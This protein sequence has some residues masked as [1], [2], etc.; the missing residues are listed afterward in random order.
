M[1]RHNQAAPVCEETPGVSI[2]VVS[3]SG[4]ILSASG[5]AIAAMGPESTDLSGRVLG[6]ILCPDDVAGVETAI[7]ALDGGQV[8]ATDVELG[9]LCAGGVC[10]RFRAFLSPVRADDRMVAV[11]MVLH[12][13]GKERAGPTVSSAPDP[14]RQFDPGLMRQAARHFGFA[15]WFLEPATRAMWATEAYFDLLGFEPDEVELSGPW[16][17]SRLHPDDFDATVSRMEQLL[18]NENETFAIDY[19]LRCKDGT[20]KWFQ[21]NARLYSRKGTGLPPVVCGSLIDIS[22]RKANESRLNAARAKA[23]AARAEAEKSESLLHIATEH[24]GVAP[25]F[26]N[27]AT[28]EFVRNDRFGTIT[29][30]TGDGL[31]KTLDGMLGMVHPDDLPMVQRELAA[32]VQGK[33]AEAKADHRIRHKDGHWV[34]CTSVAKPYQSGEDGQPL[35][36]CGTTFDI[37]DH[38]AYEAR[39]AEALRAAQ[40]AREE[41]QEAAEILRHSTENSNVVPWYRYPD[42]GQD[43]VGD[44]LKTMLGH[45]PE[46]EIDRP[47]FLDLMHPDDRSAAKADFWAMDRGEIDAYDHSFRLRR[48]D[49]TWCWF[50]AMAKRVDRSDQ[51]RP[52]LICGSLTDIDDLKRNEARL[53]EAASEAQQAQD[54]L[55]KLADNMP[56]A[57]AER[58]GWPDG[59]SSLPY[60]SARLPE[61]F[62]TTRDAIE[63]D[64]TALYVHMH[65]DDRARLVER[66]DQ[67]AAEL[68][69]FDERVRIMDPETGPRWVRI[70][71]QPF[72]Q[73][74]G[75]VIW[76]GNVNDI[77]AQVETEQRAEEAAAR[78]RFLE[79]RLR[80]A[81]E[82]AGIGVW[83]FDLVSGQLVWDDTMHR[84]HGI[85]PGSFGGRLEGWVDLVHPEDIAASERRFSAAVQSGSAF[86]DAFRIVRP[87]GTVRVISARAQIFRDASGAPV[88]A[89]GVNMDVTEQKAAELHLAEAAEDARR[90]HDR[91]NILA[92]NAPGALFE[93][94]QDS[95]GVFSLP[96]FSANLAPIM[97]VTAEALAA[98]GAA[99]F[100]HI[101]PEDLPKVVEDIAISRADLSDFT[102]RFRINDPR[103]GLRWVMVS[104]LPSL[105]SDGAVVWYGNMFDVTEQEK[106]ER[107]AAAA[108]KELRVANDRFLSMAENAPGAIFECHMAPDGE[109]DFKFLSSTLLDLMGV[110]RGD[111]VAKGR[112][113]F[114]RIPQE[115]AELI[116]PQIMQCAADLRPYEVKHRVDHPEKGLR[117]VMAAANPSLQP[118]GSI[119]W[120][121]SVV[122]ITDRLEMEHR[123]AQAAE[124][125][126][127]AH[128]SL[129]L[130]ADIST[131]GLYEFCLQPDGTTKL[132][133]FSARFAELVGFAR[134]D[135]EKSDEGVFARIPEEDLPAV[136]AAI[137]KSHRDLVP[138][139]VRFRL[140][141]PDRG[142]VW[143][144]AAANAPRLK[145]GVFTWS[146]ALS[147]VT[148]VV[149]REQELR[150]AHRLAEDMRAENERQALH[151]GLTG[152]PNRR[153]Y[154]KMIAERLASAVDGGPRDCA[155]IRLD[156]DHFKY[157][158]D[159]LGHEAG[160][161]VL[162]R[163]AAVLRDCLREGDFVA[164]I[165]GD[166][167]SI[168][169]APG[170]SEV[171][172]EALVEEI[173]VRLAEPLIYEGRQCRYG[174][175]FGIAQTEDV[176]EMGEDIQMFADAALY[177]AK[178]SGRNRLEVFTPD[179][180]REILTDRRL[181]VEIHE[182]LDR[183]QF[184]PFF[185][186]QVAAD[187]GRLVG[188][189]TLLRWK[190]PVEGL[191]S[192]DAFMHVAEQLRLVPEIDRIMMEKSRD[193][194]ANWREQGLIVPKISFNVSSGRMHDPS[195]VALAGEMASGETRVTFE[196][197]ESILVE[198]ENDT[199][200]C[201]LDMLR[202]VGVDIE[203][204]DFGS[205]HASIIGVMEIAPSALKI[206]K[207]I[208]LPV[209]QDLRARSLVRAIV[210]IADTLGIN[211]VAEGVETE[212][213]ARILRGI[214]CDVLQGYLFARPLSEDQLLTY[215]LGD[216]LSKALAGGR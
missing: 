6:D 32:M 128:D 166:E 192:P 172:A 190:H 33:Q 46:F 105:Q 124:E 208:V 116:L 86:D 100:A 213:Q 178:A 138:F 50:S 83:D 5:A 137:A 77:T 66:V 13:P 87:D 171:E 157:V 167:F 183:D 127:R 176:S 41:A 1:Q 122:D 107:Q 195:V 109:M 42:F 23:D 197:L 133:Y 64:S 141:H 130:L 82:A 95:A 2:L 106:V 57:L 98:D 18:A 75:S 35:L 200:R 80:L 187:D 115:D 103:T 59:T 182:G 69:A 132:S 22:R 96:Y 140:R 43:R 205:G 62:A 48:A 143:V 84:I 177:R 112:N 161:L 74:D 148:P 152:L 125:L 108:A 51:G 49:G 30:R 159:T 90:A 39:L 131:V 207:R 210:E 20:Y 21:A 204:D 194:L 154:D 153:F 119:I 63:K 129:T 19:R 136:R 111:V 55:R 9:V 202:E 97:G 170:V 26:L 93:F 101:H 73:P 150:R 81:T 216:G 72:A 28:G 70:S 8:A 44:H 67:S 38:K 47:A 168:L 198:E 52:L 24:A 114:A 94:R 145:D 155:L 4:H 139:S 149:E 56:G 61:M 25:W 189:E 134:E 27:P 151:D 91:L 144:L 79:E 65:Q 14:A 11:S 92:D 163:V 29:G 45:G 214:G 113:M 165:G 31:A 160:D 60:F 146:A 36:I 104:S 58:Q 12:E 85:A 3:P 40:T 147:D 212:K 211:T 126:K 89:V 164:R 37:T 186:P 15:Q 185:Q 206:D 180:H 142:M 203:I 54:R 120:H 78:L 118:D 215:A 169:M 184:V 135:L 102:A 34:W 110:A 71:S 162:V 7:R 179:L 121:G 188:I 181:A 10:R 16:L 68:S 175:S 88:R 123:A 173:R 158:N 17:R 99:V 193:A 196:L 53:A 201:H 156:L 117:W 76:Y 174:A 209:E 191:L 199:F